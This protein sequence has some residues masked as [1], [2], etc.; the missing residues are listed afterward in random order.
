[1]RRL[2]LAISLLLPTSLLASGK[3]W[4]QAENMGF[5]GPIKSVLTIRQT[6]MQVPIQPNGWSVVYPIFCEDC[7][8]DREGNQVRQ[9]KRENGG[10][11]LRKRLDE[12][13]RVEEEAWQDDKGQATSRHAYT[14]GPLGKV[15]DDY[16]LN[17]N[18]FNSTTFRY[19]SRGNEIE[20]N[21][22]KPDGTLESRDE[23]TWDDNGRP[24]DSISEG[25]GE[26]YSHVIQTYN[27]KTGHL[28]SFTS[29]HPD[30]SMRLQFRVT[31][32][33]VIFFWQQPEDKPTYGTGLCFAGEDEGTERECRN[34]K[35][36]GTYATTSY[37]FTDKTKHNPVK[38][39]LRDAN[40][41]F[42][43][44]AD[45]EYE[46]DSFGNWIKRTVWIRTQESEQRQLLEKDSRTLTYYPDVITK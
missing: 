19:D 9:G 40:S 23:T 18:L 39:V 27:P 31:E 7:E 41:K 1:M 5:A 43:M 17:G 15:R 4:T 34:Y 16:Y 33:D 25:P 24:L 45:Y 42:V 30:G 8:F 3:K 46:L 44:Q 28:E 38:V 2:A 32:D 13:G 35:W 12:F 29:L 21:V 37:T 6:F 11:A 36:D 14:N 20:R 26:N 22:Y 10:T